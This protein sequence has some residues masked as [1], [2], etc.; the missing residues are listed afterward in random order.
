MKK[1]LTE[2]IAVYGLLIIFSLILVF[3]VLALVR[4]VPYEMLWG[5]RL[6]DPEQMVIFESLSILINAVMLGVVSV[7][8]GFLPVQVNPRFIRIALWIMVVLFSVNTLG[9][10]LSKHALERIVFTP[11]T[12]LLA[13]FS[14][15]LTS[16]TA[17]HE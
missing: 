2:R 1:V 10:M 11:V 16:G 12:F 14:W 6:Q 7:R 8:A 5:G 3:H 17:E 13:I 15:R 4:I 9:N